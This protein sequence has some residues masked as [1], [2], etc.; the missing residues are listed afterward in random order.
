MALLWQR[1]SAVHGTPCSCSRFHHGFPAPSFGFCGL[2]CPAA[3]PLHPCTSHPL[4]PHCG[5]HLAKP[6]LSV[7]AD[8]NAL[9]YQKKGVRMVGS[10]RWCHIGIRTRAGCPRWGQAVTRWIP[11]QSQSINLLLVPL[12]IHHHFQ[13]IWAAHFHPHPK[14]ALELRTLEVPSEHQSLTVQVLCPTLGTVCCPRV[15]RGA[16]EGRSQG[17]PHTGCA[18]AQFQGQKADRQ[19]S[20]V[21]HTSPKVLPRSPGASQPIPTPCV[22]LAPAS[23]SCLVQPVRQEQR[24]AMAPMPGAL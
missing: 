21:T 9:L 2:S 4:A 10:H 23:P 20:A 24:G 13:H 7:R 1:V 8:N 3:L 17:W 16:H 12:T 6:V 15:P 11:A 22:L 5:G 19:S 18:L 14:E